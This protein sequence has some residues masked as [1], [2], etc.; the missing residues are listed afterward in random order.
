MLPLDFKLIDLL[1]ATWTKAVTH[2][3]DKV[4]LHLLPNILKGDEG[5]GPALRDGILKSV[6]QLLEVFFPGGKLCDLWQIN[7]APHHL[8]G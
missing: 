1:E 2:L 6:Q 8:K 7:S 4:K 5:E 3:K